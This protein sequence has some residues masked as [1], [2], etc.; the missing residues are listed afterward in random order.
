VNECDAGVVEPLVGASVMH[1]LAGLER[2][3]RCKI[4][5]EQELIED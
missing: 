2:R 3:K 5:D 4:W 1:V